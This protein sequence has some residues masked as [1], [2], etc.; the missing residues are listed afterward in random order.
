MEKEKIYQVC[1]W[2]PILDG[3]IKDQYSTQIKTTNWLSSSLW[4]LQI[5]LVSFDIID[6]PET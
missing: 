3:L 5:T 2:I 4:G 6:K 1:S